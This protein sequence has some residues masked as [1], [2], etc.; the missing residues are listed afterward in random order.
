MFGI[1]GSNRGGFTDFVAKEVQAE[2]YYIA[3]VTRGIP[4]TEKHSSPPYI[5]LEDLIRNLGPV[6]NEQW[7]VYSS[8]LPEGKH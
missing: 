7:A 2:E 1:P 5:S 6:I 3:Q 8:I 4:N